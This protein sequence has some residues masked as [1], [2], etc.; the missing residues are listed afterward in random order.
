MQEIL[1]DSK[2]AGI[3]K[4]V[5]RCLYFSR[6]LSISE[7]LSFFIIGAKYSRKEYRRDL[8]IT[9]LYVLGK[10]IVVALLVFLPE[11][12]LAAGAWIVSYLLVA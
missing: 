9:D 5:R 11:R 2:V 7:H 10:T 8:W 4:W 1:V 12:L 6:I 3:E